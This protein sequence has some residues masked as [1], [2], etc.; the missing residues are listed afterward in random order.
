MFYLRSCHYTLIH[1]LF[2]LN[3]DFYDKLSTKTIMIFHVLM[4]IFLQDHKNT[5]FSYAEINFLKMENK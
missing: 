1:I 4:F 3:D 5:I 2:S